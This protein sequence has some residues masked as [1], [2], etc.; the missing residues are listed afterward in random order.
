[1]MNERIILADIAGLCPEE[2]IWKMLV[3][4]SVLSKDKEINLSPISIIVDGQSFLPA[5]NANIWKEFQA[6][7]SEDGEKTTE[8]Q[9]VWVLG[10]L[11]YYM[12]SG[13]F[14]FGGHGGPYQKMHP[15][16][17]LPVLQ[18]R[19]RALSDIVQRCL[20][21]RPDER[22][23]LNELQKWTVKGLEMCLKNRREREDNIQEKEMKKFDVN[24]SWPEEMED[25]R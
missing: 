7:E 8:Q 21:A 9:M 18:K 1:M 17:P 2:A 24:D 23:D 3:D 5:D 16:V 11:A 10:A 4:L 25:V 13:H 14:V 19:H 15:D 12:S 20:C 22:P 6:P